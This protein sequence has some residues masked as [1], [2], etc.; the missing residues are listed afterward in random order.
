WGAI[1]NFEW[2]EG[3]EPRFG[4]IGIDYKT[5]ERI[6]KPAIK[7]YEKIAKSNKITVELLEKFDLSGSK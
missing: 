3:F 4:L 1:D 5:Q 7:M 6:I 2:N